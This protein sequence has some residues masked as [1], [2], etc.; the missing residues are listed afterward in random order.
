MDQS[1]FYLELVVLKKNNL[2]NLDLSVQENRWNNDNKDEAKER[3]HK[4]EN[5]PTF[6]ISVTN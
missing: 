5:F 6:F 4:F 3:R 1:L 2:S